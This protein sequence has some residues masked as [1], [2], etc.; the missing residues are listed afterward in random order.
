MAVARVAVIG[1]GLSGAACARALAERSVEVTVFDKGRSIGGRLATRRLDAHTFDLGAQ[2]FTA[3]HPRFEREARAWQEAGVAEPWTGR[4]VARDAAGR[5]S[6]LP[7][8]ERW[9][10]TP[11]MTSIAKHAASGLD[12]RSGHRVDR[13]EPKGRRIALLGTVAARGETLGPSTHAAAVCQDFGLFDEVAVC[14]PPE[15]AV[16]LALQLDAGSASTARAAAMEPCAALG[17]AV[18][19]RDARAL[20][21]LEADAIELRADLDD[22]S[23]VDACPIA[24]LARDSSKPGRPPG[25]RWVLHA[26]STWSASTSSLGDEASVDTLLRALDVRLGLGSLRPTAITF[27]RWALARVRRPLGITAWFDAATGIGL[28]GDWLADGTVEGSY[29]S[30]LA[31]ADRILERHR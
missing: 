24:W 13:L 6:P 5:E 27:R 3:T 2:F 12:V 26:S 8:I 23:R 18:E 22:A 16:H 9:V 1:A 17:M 11:T 19:G 29:L 28:A 31:L 21:S 20:A 30:G 14:L 4:F 15:Q 10:G 7:S 25:D